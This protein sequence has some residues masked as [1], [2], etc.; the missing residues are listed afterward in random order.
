MSEAHSDLHGPNYAD[1]KDR[2]NIIDGVESGRR[3]VFI[4][5]AITDVMERQLDFVIAALL[6]K[7][8]RIELQ[9]TLYTCMKEIVVN[10]TKANAKKTYLEA[11]GYHIE[12]M[13]DYRRGLQEIKEQLSE[14]WIEEWGARAREKG[15]EVA[16]AIEHEPDGLRIWVHNDADLLTTDEARIREKFAEGMTYQDLVSFY[17]A[18]ADQTEG[19]GMGLVMNLLLLKGENI[20][21]GL[22]RVGMRDGKTMARIEI[23]F[24]DNFKSVRGPDPGG[25]THRE[26]DINLDFRS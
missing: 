26:N 21:P 6:K 11:K 13:A 5:Y 15:L 14:K 20:N 2:Q 25:F 4:T 18:N 7:Y 3:I 23:P 12:D 16:I 24:T 10:A 9:S 22:F 17:M 8:N 19:E 1:V